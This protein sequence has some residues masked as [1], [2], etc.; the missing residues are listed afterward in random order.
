MGNRISR[1][2]ASGYVKQIAA[3]HLHDISVFVSRII[4]DYR[5]ARTHTY[6]HTYIYFMMATNDDNI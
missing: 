1:L 3:K 2:Y 6:I 4:C 5:T